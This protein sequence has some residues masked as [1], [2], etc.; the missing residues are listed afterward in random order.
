MAT[1][2]AITMVLDDDDILGEILL[3]VALATSLVRAALVCRR[4]LHIVSHPAFLRRFCTAPSGQREQP[5]YDTTHVG[6]L[7]DGAWQSITSPAGDHFPLDLKPAAPFRTVIV[8]GKHY[9]ISTPSGIAAVR[10]LAAAASSSGGTLS[11]ISTVFITPPDG[12]D[13]GEKTDLSPS[14]ADES[15]IYLVHVREL[16]LSVWLYRLDSGTWLLEDTLCLRKVCADS[17]LKPLVFQDGLSPDTTDVRIIDAAKWHG[18][19]AKFVFLKTGRRH[20]LYVDIK[21]RTAE[22][23]YAIQPAEDGDYKIHPLVM[24]WPP[25]FPIIKDVDNDKKN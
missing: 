23:V 2:N 4:W 3:R 19:D 16:Q 18:R 22:K 9:L 15:G 21:G 25:V 5:D 7:R 24:I 8:A 6:E 10:S 11:C 12:M 17:G 14:W 20:V 13:C 1:A